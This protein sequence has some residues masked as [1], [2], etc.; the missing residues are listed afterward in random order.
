MKLLI[1]SLARHDDA[2]TST[3]FQLSNCFQKEHEVLIV[4]HPYTWFELLKNFPKRIA[5]KRILA[6]FFWKP[7]IVRKEG[8][9]VLIPPALLPINFLPKGKIYR[10][11]SELNQQWLARAI[12]RALEQ[13]NWEDF[14]YI[15][16][17]NYHFPIVHRFLRG[18]I[19]KNIYHC[20][21]PIVK[22]YT[23]KHGISNERKAV[24]DADLVIS[25]AP[26]LQKKWKRIN[27]SY[28]VPNAVNFDH[29]NRPLKTIEEVRSIGQNLVGYFGNIERRMDFNLLEKTFRQHT[30]WQ[31]VLA[32]PVQ[33]QYI[34][35]TFSELP[36]VHFIGTYS[37]N[38]L[39]DLINSVDATIIPFK[40]DE[41]SKSIYPLKLYEYLSIG[42]PVISTLFNAEIFEGLKD[43]IYLADDQQTLETATIKALFDNDP[44]HRSKRRYIA[45]QNTWQDRADSFI[46]LTKRSNYDTHYQKQDK[47]LFGSQSKSEATVLKVAI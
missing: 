42:K 5:R 36:N 34:P 26:C 18:K 29:F 10:F 30:E 14:K 1:L 4:E 45:S 43:V 9:N 12:N 11:L 41:A 21:D 8:V 27:E 16:S 23:K 47:E 31:L 37:Y 35:Q 15:N 33:E 28:L 19:N 44:G 13:L 7:V 24:L 17:Y 6:T 2:T 40:C 20:V 22:S 38:E 39:P 25:T 3:T 46:Q 32:G